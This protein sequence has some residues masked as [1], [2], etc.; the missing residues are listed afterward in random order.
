MPSTEEDPAARQ[1]RQY[2]T[3]CRAQGL[4]RLCFVL[5]FDCDTPEDASA[6]LKLDRQLRQL[7][8]EATY[9]V[10]GTTLVENRDVY[11]RLAQAGREFMN[12]GFRPHA[13]WRDGAWRGITFYN[14][15]TEAEIVDDIRQGDA[16]VASVTGRRPQGFRAPHFGYFRGP[17]QRALIYRTIDA[18]GYRYASGTL[19]ELALECGPLVEVSGSIVEVPLTGSLRKPHEI[20]DSWNHYYQDR[21]LTLDYFELMRET[22]DFLVRHRLPVLLNMYVDPSHVIEAPPFLAALHHLL[23]SGAVS[24]T[25]PGLLRLSGR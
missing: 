21:V 20:L 3:L 14:E 9:A 13:E 12:H 7:G 4:D 8:V 23:A 24:L 11:R 25:F 16:A 22:V 15:L 2:S 19:P 17:E 1:F 10:P 18:F 5:S 6:A